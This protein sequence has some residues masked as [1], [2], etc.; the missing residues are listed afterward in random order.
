MQLHPSADIHAPAVSPGPMWIHL[1]CHLVTSP[2][3]HRCKVVPIQVHLLCHLQLV[4]IQL[5]LHVDAPALPSISSAAP[6][7]PACVDS[8][9][10]AV[11]AASG[12][13]S[14]NPAAPMWM[15]LLCHL[16]LVPIQ[17][18]AQLHL[19]KIVLHLQYQCRCV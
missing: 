5:Q 19:V 4:L 3:H 9:A 8:A 18:A 1:Q 11:P 15:R 6:S 10:P 16:H 13:Y 17:S 7:V 14:A 2:L 12:T